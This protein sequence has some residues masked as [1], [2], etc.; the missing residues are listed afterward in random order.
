MFVS[1][2]QLRGILEA[3]PMLVPLQAVQQGLFMERLNQKAAFIHGEEVRLAQGMMAQ[4]NVLPPDP[5]HVAVQAAVDTLAQ[6]HHA[7]QVGEA[8]MA[9]YE[10]QMG[11]EVGGGTSFLPVPP[12]IQDRVDTA[13]QERFDQLAGMTAELQA[14]P[15]NVCPDWAPFDLPPFLAA[16]YQAG[17]E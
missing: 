10:H 7:Q 9:L 12:F 16:R 13:R 4:P 6:M 1:P 15:P 11:W 3:D 5:N 2:E 17:T 8:T 14:N